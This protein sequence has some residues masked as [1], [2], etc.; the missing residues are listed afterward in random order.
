MAQPDPGQAIRR[1]IETLLP[2]TLKSWTELAQTS[3]DRINERLK[4]SV[5]RRDFCE[6]FVDCTFLGSDAP[7]ERAGGSLLKEADMLW[8]IP[9]PPCAAE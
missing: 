9:A 7:E 3:R 6:R 1:R 4:P 2:H 5:L 8:E